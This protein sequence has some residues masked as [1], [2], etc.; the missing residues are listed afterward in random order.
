MCVLDLGGNGEASA[1]NDYK[2]AFAVMVTVLA[3]SGAM[4]FFCLAASAYAP[5]RSKISQGFSVVISLF[6]TALALGATSRTTDTYFTE[7]D[8]YL[9]HCESTESFGAAGYICANICWILGLAIVFMNIF[10]F[11]RC[12]L[13]GVDEVV[14]TAVDIVK[15]NDL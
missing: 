13:K 9:K 6:I 7:P 12:L 5:L 2:P 11:C 15:G 8:N 4:F 14:D 3:I 1:D 10:P